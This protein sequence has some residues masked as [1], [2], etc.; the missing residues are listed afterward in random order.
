MVGQNR[1]RGDL[2]WQPVFCFLDGFPEQVDIRLRGEK[3]PAPASDAC[4]DDRVSGDLISVETGYEI[5]FYEI[6]QG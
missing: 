1:I 6:S 2:E 4:Y 3:P 5:I